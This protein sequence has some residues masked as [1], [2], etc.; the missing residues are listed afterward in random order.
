MQAASQIETGVIVRFCIDKMTSPFERGKANVQTFRVDAFDRAANQVPLESEREFGYFGRVESYE[1]RIFLN[2]TFLPGF[3]QSLGNDLMI[4][5]QRP[6]C[7]PDH[8]AK[9]RIV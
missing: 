4:A 7:A 9:T 3:V 5:S 2:N 6:G 8:F 1:V